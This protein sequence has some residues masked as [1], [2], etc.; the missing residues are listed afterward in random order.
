MKQQ[1]HS[2][3]FSHFPLIH[4]LHYTNTVAH[5]QV[6]LVTSPPITR[7]CRKIDQNGAAEP[8][9]HKSYS[10]PVLSARPNVSETT[11][12]FKETIAPSDCQQLASYVAPDVHV[13]FARTFPDSKDDAPQ[14]LTPSNDGPAPLSIQGSDAWLDR[15]LMLPLVSTC[16]KHIC[17]SPSLA[18]LKALKAHVTVLSSLPPIVSHR[19]L[20][21]EPV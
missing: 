20:V 5:L 15:P 9:A 11:G 10:A 19:P 1:P 21:L 18:S 3:T 12:P 14:F 2:I 4:R 13:G 16:P 8:P 17:A 6:W 7:C